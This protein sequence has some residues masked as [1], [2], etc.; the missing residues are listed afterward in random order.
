[1]LARSPRISANS[2]ANAGFSKGNPWGELCI[3]RIADGQVLMRYSPGD[4]FGAAWRGRR[5]VIGLA[6]GSIRVIRIGLPQEAPEDLRPP[7]R[8]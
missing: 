7:S 4:H 8:P 3:R 1:M 6:D 2:G 5:L